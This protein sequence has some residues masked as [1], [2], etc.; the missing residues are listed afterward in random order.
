MRRRTRWRLLKIGL[1]GWVALTPATVGA[2]GSA[3]AAAPA[4]HDG[5]KKVTLVTGDVVT[6]GEQRGDL[7]VRRIDR[8]TGR[9]RIDFLTTRLNGHLYVIPS[10]A[11][12]LLGEGRL[13]ER[14][15]DLTQLV[16]WGYD[17]AHRKDVPLLAQRSGGSRTPLKDASVTRSFAKAKIDAVRV[18]KAEAGSFWKDLTGT[19]PTAMLDVGV[20]ALWLDGKRKAL[21]DKSVPQIGAPAAWRKGLTGKG[22]TVAVLDTGYDEKHPDLKGVVTEAKGFTDG[23]PDDVQDHFGHG[24]HVTSTVAGSGAASGGRYKGV[25][26]DAKVIMGKVLDDDGQGQDSWALAGME[27]AA[28]KAKI[29]SMSLGAQDFQGADPLEQAVNSLTA[30]TGA[31]FVIAAGNDGPD[32]RS[33]SSP[34]TADAALAVGAVDR[35]DGLTDFSSRGP[36]LGDYAVK[37]DIT[38]PGLDI[39]AAVP[40]DD[41]NSADPYEEMSGTSMA[42]PHVAGAAAILLQQHPDWTGQRLKAALMDSAKPTTDTVYRQGAGRVDV[43]RAVGQPVTASTGGLSFG[44]GSGPQA[45]TYTND[46]DEAMTLHLTVH[47]TSYQGG[48][49]QDGLFRPD[50]ESVAVPPHGTAQVKVAI[51]SEGV[52]TGAYGGI[53]TATS[54]DTTVRTVLGAYL[55]PESADLTVKAIDRSGNPTESLLVVQDQKTSFHEFLWT[56]GGTATGRFPTGAYNVVGQIRTPATDDLL[57]LANVPVSLTGDREVVVDARKAV[58]PELAVDD[59]TAEGGKYGPVGFAYQRG[60]A[61]YDVF[62]QLWPMALISVIPVK[63]GGLS[64]LAQRTFFKKGATEQ[65]PSPYRYEVVDYRKGEIPR[66]PVHT[67]K[68]ADMA[69]VAVTYRAQDAAADAFDVVG[70]TLPDGFAP[71]GVVQRFPLPFTV[72]Q[73]LTADPDLRWWRNLA[74]D[75]TG[76]RF[77]GFYGHSQNDPPRAY[78]PGDHRE[79]WN[80]AVVGPAL[81][82]ICAVTTIDLY[83]GAC[84]VR[85][86]D[87]I[88]YGGAAYLLSESGGRDH[89]GW[90]GNADGTATLSSGGKTIAQ[91]SIWDFLETDLPSGP[92]KYELAVSAH[93]STGTYTNLSSEVTARYVFS[94]GTTSAK[95]SLPLMAVR[96]APR[97]LDEQNRAKPGST[98]EIP[99]RVERNPGAASSSVRS[100]TVS[101]STDDGATWKE[102]PLTRSGTGWIA[103]VSAPASGYVSLRATVTDQAGDS[104]DQTVI[105]AYAVS[106]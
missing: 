22:V 93:R 13:D 56:R 51:A 31:L 18:D 47:A 17:D 77:P 7:S 70:V 55:E 76:S 95:Q 75:R 98:T 12:R 23:G 104:A 59:P 83:N 24:T 48:A 82:P 45:V 50:V 8:G 64:Y 37:P 81:P 33:L 66:N 25:A 35:S 71:Y 86:G 49:A 97:G 102:V 60:G 34:A 43:A 36:R 46:S 91:G 19:R 94:S 20:T 29:V 103:K 10:D 100:L 72:T 39:R 3:A 101:A 15:F 74:Y 32:D 42:T 89:Y 5:T 62:Q 92:A 67:A 73:Y 57:T 106:G 4:A 78:R 87:R 61:S 54:G 26:P 2:T 16:K 88:F 11:Q 99:L 79:T 21:L 41:T 69:R 65:D 9:Q 28:G 84:G 80:A 44:A 27:W 53:L 30:S 63:E 68:A 14:V 38:A 6:L 105:R 90:D 85:K 96:Y 58:Q 1:A 52:K 40:V